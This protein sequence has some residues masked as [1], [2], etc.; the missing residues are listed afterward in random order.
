MSQELEEGVITTMKQLGFTATDAKAYLALIKHNPATGYELATRSGVP[1]SA[2]YGVLRRLESLG[3][4]NAIQDKPAR[5]VPL[6]PESLHQLLETRFRRSLG[7]LRDSLGQLAGQRR[8]G[9]TWTVHGYEAMLEQAE[10]LIGGAESSVYGS[11]WARE[12]GRFEED[13]RAAHERGVEVVLFSF[14]P[15]AIE[16]A[17][18]FSYGIKE[19]E[20]ESH[21]PHKVILIADQERA[22][23][24]GAEEADMNRAVI[25]EEPA[26]V[27]MA[28]SN[29]V[30]DITLLGQRQERDVSQVVTRLTKLLAP[31]EEMTGS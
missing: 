5:Y 9:A 28:V 30:L 15:L 26:L 29:L 20:L 11:L 2:I 3:L 6:A 23:V 14:N 4:I 17:E 25:T 10:S 22:L 19:A 18:V 1:R 13:F 8:Q 7:D 27:E 16:H 12:A 21:W 24:G 31:V